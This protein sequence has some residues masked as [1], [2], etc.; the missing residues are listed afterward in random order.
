LIEASNVPL[1]WYVGLDTA[2][3][4]IGDALWHGEALDEAT[5]TRIVGLYRLTFVDAVP[6][7]PMVGSDPVYL[8][9]AMTPDQV[10]RMKP[11]NLVVGLPIRRLESVS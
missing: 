8:I 10:L 6:A 3:T 7:E 2:G 1:T 5:R 4:K 9:L 11:Q